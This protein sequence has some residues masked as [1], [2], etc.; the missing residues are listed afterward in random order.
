MPA[1]AAALEDLAPAMANHLWQSTLFAAVAAVLALA[2]R[3]NQARARYWIDRD[4]K[5]NKL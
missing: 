3:K 4:R 1:V 5:R 2:L